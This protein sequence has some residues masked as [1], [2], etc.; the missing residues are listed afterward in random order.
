MSLTH[1]FGRCAHIDLIAQKQLVHHEYLCQPQEIHPSNHAD[2]RLGYYLDHVPLIV[3][4]A[5]IVA[6]SLSLMTLIDRSV[7][8]SHRRLQE[9]FRAWMASR[10]GDGGAGD[11][12]GK[13]GAE[14]EFV[15]ASKEK[16]SGAQ[17]A[18]DDNSVFAQLRWGLLALTSCLILLALCALLRA[19]PGAW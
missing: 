2:T 9:K 17:K 19:K 14:N 10:A 15:R 13:D 8:C 12:E 11:G 3:P 4:P 1:A 5:L 6:L 16:F 18:L 7:Y